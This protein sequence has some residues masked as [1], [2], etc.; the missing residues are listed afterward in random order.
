MSG[1]KTSGGGIIFSKNSTSFLVLK[2]ILPDSIVV[3]TVK[4]ESKDYRTGSY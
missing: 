4:T 1:T 3:V 2:L